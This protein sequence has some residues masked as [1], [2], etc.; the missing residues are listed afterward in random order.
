MDSLTLKE[1]PRINASELQ[2]KASESDSRGFFSEVFFG[3]YKNLPVAVKKMKDKKMDPREKSEVDPRIEGNIHHLAQHDYVVK[4]YGYVNDSAYN[5]LVMELCE[6][7]TLLNFLLETC[8]YE[9]MSQ[10]DLFIRQIALALLHL[11]EVCN[12]L[13]L[14]LKP[15][16]LLLKEESG[17][18]VI[19]ITDFGLSVLLKKGETEYT[20]DV[21]QGSATYASPERIDFSGKP[22]KTTAAAVM[23]ACGIVLKLITAGDP[24]KVVP[25]TRSD[26]EILK[27]N[28]EGGHQY[29]CLPDPQYATLAL[30]N[31]MRS[32]LKT[33]PHERMDA[34]QVVEELNKQKSLFRPMI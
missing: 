32:L 2:L 25:Q 16:N 29:T 27:F 3:T 14:D 34:R 23:F 13:H 21:L 5:G 24:Y 11:H 10:R 8:L 31:I 26:Y 17:T 1:L 7:G 15:E 20:S 9:T 33:K 18:T 19:K 12:I 28:H 30:Y 6:E 4:L 22:I